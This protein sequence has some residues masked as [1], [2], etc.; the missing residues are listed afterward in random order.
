MAAV[1]SRVWW[2]IWDMSAH[3]LQAGLG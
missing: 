3:P 2:Y 1:S